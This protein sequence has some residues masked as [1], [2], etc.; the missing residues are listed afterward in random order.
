MKQY[1]VIIIGAGSGG[2]VAAATACGLGASVLLIENRK[3]GGDCLNYGCVPSK[4]FL[5]S[6]RIAKS[7]KKA[8]HY[9]ITV[10]KPEISL[11]KIMDRVKSVIAEIAP[12]DSVERFTSL[13]ADVVLGHAEIVSPNSVKVSETVYNTRNIIIAT[14][15]S[16]VIPPI[17]GLDKVPFYTNENIFDL[18]TLPRK[19]VVLGA[20]PIGL[21][22]GQGF[23]Q[24]GSEVCIIDRSDSLFKKDEPEVSEILIKALKDDGVN[25]YLNS[26][27]LSVERSA[28]ENILKIE[29]DG[30]I[31]DL[32]CD[33]ILIALGRKPNTNNLG[34]EKVGI[35]TDKRGFIIV[36]EKLQTSIPHIFACGDVRGKYQFTHTASY[37]AS[38]AIKNALISNTFKTS[39][40]N[41]C[42]AT[43]TSPE[44]A[45][46][47][48]LESECTDEGNYTLFI[49]IS[50]NDRAK[51]D[52]DRH[53][54]VKLIMDK[55][56]R[57]IGATIVSEKASEMLTQFSVLITN[58]MQLSDVLSVIYQ[59]PI[60]GEIIKSLATT[61]FKDHV[62]PW[63]RT[64]IKK[65]VNRGEHYD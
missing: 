54:F 10:A 61:D 39:Y 25:L 8:D 43:Y 56:R 55:K 27:I 9:G 35:E 33:T 1:D 37:E 7:I 12:H 2:L 34:L 32:T 5:K 64:I 13:G 59:Y 31:I 20:G 41:V 52:D 23:A 30:K 18:T 38:V 16:A 63:Q 29:Q 15:S 24:L 58:K 11:E 46:V 36:N 57:I 51:A 53:G 26:K 6:C 65:I 48:L 45:H 3:M 44:V 28:D 62:K 50:D 40:S 14:G 22:L 47:G 4:T 49:E 17:E 19:M 60:Q 42:W 21:E